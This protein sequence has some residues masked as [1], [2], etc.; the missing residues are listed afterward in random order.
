MNVSATKTKAITTFR[1]PL[2]RKLEI[3]NKSIQPQGKSR[4]YQTAI[5]L[6]LT[7]TAET[8]QKHGAQNGWTL[9]D[10]KM[11]GDIRRTCRLDNTEEESNGTNKLTV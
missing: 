2:K 5:R 4:T 3:D 6:I 7:Y 8:R 11:S 1:T 9:L 10:R